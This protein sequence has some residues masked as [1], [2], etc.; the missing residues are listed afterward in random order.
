MHR[1]AATLPILAFGPLL[2]SAEST[3]L[4]TV[5]PQVTAS[6]TG[7]LD[8]GATLRRDRAF[9]VDP[10][11]QGDFVTLPDAVAS[12]PP[13]ALLL[14][15]PGVYGGETVI[16]KSLRIESLVPDAAQIGD[17]LTVEAIGPNQE[18][19]LGGLRFK[20]GFLI[21]NCVGE[22][23]LT[24]CSAILDAEIALHPGV[25]FYYYPSCGIGTS[26]HRVVSS[27]AVTFVDCS[28]EGRH[29]YEGACDGYPG[30]HGLIVEDSRVAVYGGALMGGPGGD[31]FWCHGTYPGAGG[32]GLLARGPE[33]RVYLQDVLLLGALGGD[34][35]DSGVNDGCDGIPERLYDGATTAYGAVDRLTLDIDSLVEPNSLPSYT[36]TAPPGATLYIMLAPRRAWREFTAAEGLFHLGTGTQ[37]IPLGTMGASGSLTRPF[38]AP[39]TPWSLGFAGWELQA[40]A[41]VAGADRYSEP[42]TLQA[43]SVGF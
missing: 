5:G 32:D 3:P 40:Y 16:A 30:E 12:V 33:T 42:R 10:S 20:E 15:E 23:N 14:L 29:G 13:G 9:L 6:V 39:P 2:A 43:T 27:D 28:L 7:Q 38:P 34:D 31:G 37:L 35:T 24:D 11:G 36:I 26:R 22:V 1:L 25:N 8:T 41:Q 19:Y 18:V 21:E 4:R 17:L